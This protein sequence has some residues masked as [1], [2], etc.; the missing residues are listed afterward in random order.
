MKII[1]SII[2]LFLTS[3]SIS[4]RLDGKVLLCNHFKNYNFGASQF[5]AIIFKDNIYYTKFIKRINDDVII[6]DTKSYPNNEYYL[7]PDYIELQPNS[8]PCDIYLNRKTLQKLN[9]CV[10]NINGFVIEDNFWEKNKENVVS[11]CQ[12]YNSEN[13]VMNTLESY[14]KEKQNELNEYLKKNKI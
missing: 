11:T 7:N 10:K 4:E 2:F 9:S 13:E 14:R 12:V 3:Q 5:Y 8:S 1:L 6:A